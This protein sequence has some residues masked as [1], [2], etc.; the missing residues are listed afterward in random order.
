MGGPFF[1]RVPMKRRTLRFPAVPGAGTIRNLVLKR[2]RHF[3]EMKIGFYV[4]PLSAMVAAAVFLA[5]RSFGQDAA[6]TNNAPP[7]ALT[8][9]AAA[10]EKF[11]NIHMEATYVGQWHPSFRAQYSGPESLDNHSATA[12]TVDY[13]LF[14]GARLWQGAEFHVDGLYW[15]GFGFNHTLG[16]EA[17]PN[18]EAYKIGAQAGNVAPVR[19]FIRQTIGLGGDQEPVTDDALH[20]GGQQ[21]VSRITLTVGQISVLDIFDQNSYAGDPTTQFLN[22]A[23]VGNEAW[24]Y[25]ANSI[26]Y[27]TGFAAELNQPNWTA[28]Y[29]MFQMPGVQN[30]MAINQQY[31][32]AWGMVTEFERRFAIH[33]H[34][35]AVR[36]LA[37]LNRADMGS[38]AEALENP[39]RPP[40]IVDTRQYRLKYGFGLNA[41]YELIQGV[42]FFTRLGWNDGQTE[43]WAYADVDKSGSAGLSIKGAFWNR[44]NDTVGLAGVVNGI[45]R[46]QQDFFAAGGLGILAGDGALSYGLEKTLETYYKAQIWKNIYATADYQYV[47]D[48]AYNAARGPV[49]ILGLRLHWEF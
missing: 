29:G 35:G 20:L 39:Q 27:I 21:D 48:P 24:D 11:W 28:R 8:N 43:N 18:A 15:Q 47:I 31:L 16:I 22:W 34:P 25:P 45:S 36:L 1:G 32:E 33:D 9:S 19:V 7:P 10:P 30:G 26:G 12:E 46:V 49:S 38:Y 42:G 6:R 37:Y 41:E 40:N 23:L 3:I 5:G 44:P 17:F 14:L 4:R 13:D 2:D